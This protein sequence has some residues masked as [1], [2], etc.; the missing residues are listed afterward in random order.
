[1]LLKLHNWLKKRSRYT[2]AVVLP[3]LIWTIIVAGVFGGSV[4]VKRADFEITGTKEL[5]IFT[6][7]LCVLIA[8]L[9]VFLE[10]LG[11]FLFKAKEWK[12]LNERIKNGH[13]LPNVS[14][15]ELL[16]IFNILQNMHKWMVLRDGEYTFGTTFIVALVEWIASKNIKNVIVILAGGTL[17]SL[18]SLIGAIVFYDLFLIPLRKECKEMLSRR[19][20][21]FQEI[22]FTS[23]KTKSNLFILLLIILLVGFLLIIKPLNYTLVLYGIILS[24]IIFVLIDALFSTI[25][26]T[27]SEIKESAKELAKG[28]E[29]TFFSGSADAEIL[30]LSQSLKK[31]AKDLFNYQ[32]ALEEEK[33]S[34]EIRVRARTRELEEL[35]KS[36][37]QKVKERTAELEKRIKELEKFHKL[38]IGRELKM[39]ELKEE[40]KR[41][42]EKLKHERGK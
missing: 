5:F 16:K 8:S 19:K 42:K 23:L 2:F 25:Y 18:W 10:F 4:V 32:K 14:D 6:L 24:C 38:I 15:E 30:D 3:Q 22:H 21:N 29:A 26:V 9:L 33:T 40:I 35:T 1:M 36:L 17:A 34:L 12:F 11:I 41:L 28:R 39:I 31:T 27:L 7:F 20:L 13:I 37:D